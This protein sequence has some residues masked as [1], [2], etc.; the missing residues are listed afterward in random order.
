MTVT[1][2]CQG[3][4][5]ITKARVIFTRSST[6]MAAAQTSSESITVF[7]LPGREQVGRGDILSG[8][9][10]VARAQE[11]YNETRDEELNVFIRE[12]GMDLQ[13]AVEKYFAQVACRVSGK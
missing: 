2:A 5:M 11:I 8:E 4:E 6:G 12:S 10:D 1:S 3:G 7:E 13:T 9:W